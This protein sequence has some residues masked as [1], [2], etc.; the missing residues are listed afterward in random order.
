MR[1]GVGAFY[2]AQLAVKAQVHYPVCFLPCHL[3]CVTIIFINKFKER[4][5]ARTVVDTH[6][7]AVTNVKLTNQFSPE[8]FAIPEFRVFVIDNA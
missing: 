1:W 7:A 5:E 8:I 4:G 3:V 2:K 6:A